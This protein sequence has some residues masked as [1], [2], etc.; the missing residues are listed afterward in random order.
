SQG[1]SRGLVRIE[2]D[3]RKTLSFLSEHAML[4]S[5]GARSDTIPVL[6]ILCRDV[7]AT[8]SS[9]VAPV[10]PEKVFYLASRGIGES[11]AIRM[12]GEGFLAHVLDRAPI[13]DLREH[14]YPILAARWDGHPVLFTDGPGGPALPPLSAKGANDAAEWRFD[15]KL[16]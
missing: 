14:L 1:V 7:K 4:L 15:A 3:A 13:V 12:I 2:K 6:E 8:H 9:S 11:D 10:D 16:R 5:R